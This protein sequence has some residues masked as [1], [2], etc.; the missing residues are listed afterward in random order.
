M[1]KT[2]NYW[3]ERVE[4][5][6]T[7]VHHWLQNRR[8]KVFNRG[9]LRLCGETL[10]LCGGAWNSKNWQKLHWFIVFHVS[11]WGV[12]S[13]VLGPKPTKDP[14]WRRGVWLMFSFWTLRDSQACPWEWDS[15]GNP[16]GNVPW[17]GIGQAMSMIG[18]AILIQCHIPICRR[19]HGNVIP[20]GIPWDGMGQHTFVFPMRLRNR[21]RVSEFYWIVI[22]R[23]YFWILKS[24]NFVICMSLC[25]C[26]PI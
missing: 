11:I 16:M 19:V 25:T 5:R 12:W 18:L 14:P 23:L 8:Q 10:H 26:S 15:Y 3:S 4:R 17:D 21:M 2:S 6:C 13:F 1:W 24:I 7:Y 20:M 9:A 22:L